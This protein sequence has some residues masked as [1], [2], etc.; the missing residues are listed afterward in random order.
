VPLPSLPLAAT[1]AFPL[2]GLVPNR[3]F[4]VLHGEKATLLVVVVVVEEAGTEG[5]RNRAGEEEEVA[6]GQQRDIA[7]V[8]PVGRCVGG[9]R[10]ARVVVVVLV[11][12]VGRSVAADAEEAERGARVAQ[13]RRASRD[14]RFGGLVWGRPVPSPC[15]CETLA[16]HR[17]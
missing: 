2:L 1:G 11:D 7:A 14:P 15:G 17:S 5:R 4:P 12:P 8:R 10:M 9:A 6:Q 16:S 3:S 13:R